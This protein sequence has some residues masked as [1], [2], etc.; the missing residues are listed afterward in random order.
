MPADA[1]HTFDNGVRLYEK[2]LLPAQLERYAENNVHEPAEEEQFL[3]LVQRL[4]DRPRLTMA[5]VG[6][7]VGYYAILLRRHVPHSTVI[8]FEPLE[9]HA[10][11]LSDNLRLNGVDG[12]VTIRREAVSSSVGEARFLDRDFSSRLLL[13]KENENGTAAVATTTMAQ[14]VERDGPIDIV[15]VDVQGNEVNVLAGADGAFDRIG[16]W[17][18]GTHGRRIHETCVETLQAAGYEILFDEPQPD[19]QPD[20]VVVAARG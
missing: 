5:D 13:A 15:K 10:R 12:G 18:I 8:C 7:A 6:A 14:V 11:A 1:V 17:I 16:S 20:G 2:H 9:A 19:G 3:R 4:A